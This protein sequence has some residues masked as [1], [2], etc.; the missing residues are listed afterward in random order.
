[1][2]AAPAPRPSLALQHHVVARWLREQPLRQF[3][4]QALGHMQCAAV[5]LGMHG[6]QRPATVGKRLLILNAAHR[7]GELD[8]CGFL[9]F[10]RCFER[11]LETQRRRG[12]HHSCGSETTL[13]QPPLRSS[14]FL[15]A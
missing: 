2:A 12:P 15:W 9:V 10:F 1:V 11:R 13:V 8:A 7:L 14:K 3:S 5:V 4:R 6:A